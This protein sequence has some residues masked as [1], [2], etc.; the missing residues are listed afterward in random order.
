MPLIK[1]N[2]IQRIALGIAT[3]FAI[4][5]GLL[6]LKSYIMLAILSAIVVILFNPLYKRL[7]RKGRKPSQAALLTFLASIFSVI[8]P[9]LVVGAITILQIESLVSDLSDGNYSVNVTEIGTSIIDYINSILFSLGVS[10]QLSIE[11]M[12][13]YISSA[14][15]QFGKA[16][17]EGVI[18]SISG[19]FSFITLAIIYIYVFMSMIINQDKILNIFKQLNPLG[20]EISDIYMQRITA[21]TKA[22][23][24]GQ[25]IIALCQGTA[26]AIV[27]AIAGL[28]EL[29]FFFWMLLT[30][31]SI[32]PLG[33]G[34]VTIPIGI[35]MILTG[36]IWQGVLV[37]ANHLI[38]VTNID[39]VLRPRLVPAEAKLDSAL[40]ILAVFAGLAVFGFIGIVIG[41]VLMILIVTTIQVYLEVFKLTESI[42]KNHSSRTKKRILNK[43]RFWSKD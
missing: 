9:V 32:V 22:T 7:L 28:P 6:F 25:F 33:A 18:S 38:V 26:S 29:F 12:A 21:M 10:Y 2:S 14:A 41:P 35:L 30:V 39:N 16:L 20:D 31:L 23:V 43:A 3:G 11:S 40:M 1:V 19:I 27:L 5:V 15:E 34:I 24:R 36:N 4:I 13:A 17:V 42:E 8:I 37:I